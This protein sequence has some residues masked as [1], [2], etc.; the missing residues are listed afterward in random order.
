MIRE[1]FMRS[2]L[3]SSLISARILLAAVWASLCLSMIAAPLL[4]ARGCEPAATLLY[5]F[6]SPVCHQVPERSFLISGHA[7]AVCH[8]CAGIYFGLLLA[9]VSGNLFIGRFLQAR[10][11]WALAA[12]LPLLL[13]ALLPH[14]GLWN[15]S[16]TSR[17]L[18]GA[19]FG[20]MASS[21]LV[22]GVTELLQE[23][24]W[25]RCLSR[26][27]HFKEAVHE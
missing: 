4:S 5:L 8:R 25:R 21:L 3:R 11:S 7:W 9:A 15:S 12:S 10:R 13:D 17:F 2:S 1:K 26:I 19:L 6:F 18:S 27:P 16:G 24:P 20:I 22:L 23:A 14:A